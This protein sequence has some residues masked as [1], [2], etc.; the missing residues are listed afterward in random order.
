[1]SQTIETRVTVLEKEINQVTGLFGRLDTTIDKLSDVSSSIKQ[2]LAVHETKLTQHEKTHR[3]VYDEIERRRKESTEQH[4]AL[5][6]EMATMTSNFKKEIEDVER[7]ITDELKCM[8][9]EQKKELEGI[10]TSF[11]TSLESVSSKTNK[12]YDWKTMVMGGGIVLMFFINL[13]I[14]LVTSGVI[15]LAN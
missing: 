5:Q 13:I 3:D 8:R 6:K 15:P 11:S 7:K 14:G 1:M 2:L 12:V 4:I 9:D 10:K